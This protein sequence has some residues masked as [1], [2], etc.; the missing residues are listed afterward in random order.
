[1][2]RCKGVNISLSNQYS[3]SERVPTIDERTRLIHSR[4]RTG[5][6]V[7]RPLTRAAIRRRLS[8]EIEIGH[9]T[10]WAS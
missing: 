5:N 8:L 10:L 3:S 7:E 2:K 4:L 9:L 1:M 6:L